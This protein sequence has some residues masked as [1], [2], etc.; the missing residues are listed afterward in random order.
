VSTGYVSRKGQKN[1]RRGHVSILILRGQA[2]AL[3][4]LPYFR[5]EEIRRVGLF[6]LVGWVGLGTFE[7]NRGLVIGQIEVSPLTMFVRIPHLA[8]VFDTH[9]TP[10]WHP[11][12]PKRGA[13][14]NQA[15][16]A[17]ARLGHAASQRNRRIRFTLQKST[18]F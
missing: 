4:L 5:L 2:D 13:F 9:P 18:N 16:G 6:S 17:F 7:S 12:T 15:Y 3:A 1:D 8:C 10:A 14:E 11:F